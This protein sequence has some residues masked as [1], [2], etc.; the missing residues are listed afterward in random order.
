[1]SQIFLAFSAPHIPVDAVG[2]S[3]I[4]AAI[5]LVEWHQRAQLGLLLHAKVAG[6]PGDRIPGSGAGIPRWPVVTE[7]LSHEVIEKN[8]G[9]RHAGTRGWPV[10]LRGQES[11]PVCQAPQGLLH[12]VGGWGALRK[13]ALPARAL[14]DLHGIVEA[15]DVV[16]GGGML[17]PA[18][19]LVLA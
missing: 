18:L 1:A 5:D 15:C 16:P 3:G 2:H 13:G 4:V 12:T 6:N 17:R 14:V 9:W 10:V 11:Q 8:F 19:A 7:G